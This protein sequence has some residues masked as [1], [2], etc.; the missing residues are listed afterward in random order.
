[1]GYMPFPLLA[2][3]SAPKTVAKHRLFIVFPMFLCLL[4]TS[5]FSGL[6]GDIMADTDTAVG[7]F[8]TAQ[9]QP[10]VADISSD[11]T[12]RLMPGSVVIQDPVQPILSNGE[13][14]MVSEGHF[15][16]AAGSLTL[17]GWNGGMRVNRT[18]DGVIVMAITTPVLIHTDGGDVLVPARRQW[19]SYG[20]VHTPEQG[21]QR[22]LSERVTQV[23]SEKDLRI[24]LPLIAGLLDDT[25]TPMTLDAI[26]S[27]AATSSGWLLAAFHQDTRDLTWTLPRPESMTKEQHL[28]SLASFLPADIL[29]VAYT[30]I[31]FDRWASDLK[32][33][34]SAENDI[35]LKV[36]VQEQAKAFSPEQMPER[37]ERA[38]NA[39][40]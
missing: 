5:M 39:L 20:P 40:D 4:G 24:Q 11:A 27:M 14:T 23:V 8:L 29:P 13:V 30:S 28:L 34:L 12:A 25:E 10:L 1:M 16:L 38:G 18:D 15:R 36:V 22:W 19:T 6:P 37:A 26:H 2:I 33:Y 7:S 32:E 17:E 21:M 9:S 31:A 35:N 3:Q